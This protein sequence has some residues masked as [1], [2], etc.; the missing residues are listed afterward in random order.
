MSNKTSIVI[1]GGGAVA[2][3]VAQALDKQL[4]PSKYSLTMLTE[5]DYYR[6]LPAA[7]RAFVTAEGDLESQM[8]FPYDKIFG[9]DTKNGI[10]RVG[11]VQLGKVVSVEEKANDKGYVVLEGGQRIEWNVLL[12]A[13]GSEWEGP[14]RWPNRLSDLES[15]M[16]FPYDKIFGK[17]TKNGIG[18]VGTV[19]LGKVV[20]VEE[21]AND[22]GYVV[23][24]GGQRVEWNVLLIATGSEVARGLE[25]RGVVILNGD[26]VTG[27]EQ[28]VLDGIQGVVPGRT[29]TTTKGVTLP[30]ELI[31]PTRGSRRVNTTFLGD[32][33]PSAVTINAALVEQGRLDV[34][35][36]LQLTSNPNVF[37]GGDVVALNEAHTIVK[38]W[39][40][41]SVIVENILALLTAREN[42]TEVVHLKK[43]KKAMDGIAI[44]NGARRGT[45]YL[46]FFTIPI[47]GWPIILGDWITSTLKS[48]SLSAG[49][50]RSWMGQ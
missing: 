35:R 41:T 44:T 48:Q 50:I 9:K 14:L 37:A 36:T 46:D 38:A 19:Q 49:G 28:D 40:H 4:S 25:D 5:T 20:S 27:L 45:M 22:K 2:I 16:T 32:N 18:R 33:S 13:T 24:E 47:L 17:D 23:L 34:S 6:H 8:T 11:T 29:I 12:I 43:Y 26:S 3:H 42:G 31:I 39:A 1:V 7:L 10:G 21:K 30:A 15:Q